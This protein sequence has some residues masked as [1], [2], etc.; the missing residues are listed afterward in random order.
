[1]KEACDTLEKIKTQL[2]DDGME[3]QNQDNERNTEEIEDKDVIFRDIL[4]CTDMSNDTK[5]KIMKSL[6][7]EQSSRSKVQKQLE[8]RHY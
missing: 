5:I 3:W 2:R 4:T 1:M 6:M 7:N 8:K